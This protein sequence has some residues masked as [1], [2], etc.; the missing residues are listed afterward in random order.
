MHRETFSLDCDTALRNTNSSNSQQGV[1]KEGPALNYML[2]LDCFG[3]AGE[4]GGV[5]RA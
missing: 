5:G 1:G 2:N 4:A 3:G